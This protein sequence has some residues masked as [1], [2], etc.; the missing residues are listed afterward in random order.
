[1]IIAEEKMCIF[2]N[3]IRYCENNPMTASGRQ[4]LGYLII[5]TIIWL[6]ILIKLIWSDAAGWIVLSIFFAPAVILAILMIFAGN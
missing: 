5:L 3:G 2:Q 1:M 4:A 6:S